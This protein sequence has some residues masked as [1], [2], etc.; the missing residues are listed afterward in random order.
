MLNCICSP[1]CK[2]LTDIYVIE[3][4]I[5]ENV[6]YIQKNHAMHGQAEGSFH[7]YVQWNLEHPVDDI[8]TSKHDS[9]NRPQ[10]AKQ[11]TSVA[12]GVLHARSGISC[13]DN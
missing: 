9:R 3:N 1:I 8:C 4:Q 11:F 10:C 2:S 12:C 5:N 7:R 6:E 13:C